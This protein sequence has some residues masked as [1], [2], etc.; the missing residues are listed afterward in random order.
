MENKDKFDPKSMNKSLQKKY[1]I[2][3]LPKIL[4]FHMKRFVKNEFFM[5][6]NI[7]IVKFPL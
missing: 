3:K 1:T 2:K 5:E 7:T 4:I 6:K